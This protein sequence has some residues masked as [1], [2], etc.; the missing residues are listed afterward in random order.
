MVIAKHVLRLHIKE[1]AVLIVVKDNNIILF[2]FSLEWS[3]CGQEWSSW[4]I[5]YV[6][7]DA[8]RFDN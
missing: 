6:I 7:N 5:S 8:V 4:M 2:Y 3:T 1:L